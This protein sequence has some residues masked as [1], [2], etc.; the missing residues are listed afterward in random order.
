MT[1]N[2][3][4]QT[5]FVNEEIDLGELFKV[6]RSKWKLIVIALIL[7]S[8]AGYLISSLLPNQYATK[9][10]ILI[11]EDQQSDPLGQLQG[12]E[13][14]D[15]FGGLT[16]D[17]L[18]NEIE[19]LKSRTIIGNV[20][21]SLNLNVSYLNND[22]LVKAPIYR[23][24]MPFFV[25]ATQVKPLASGDDP[26]INIQLNVDGTTF[27]LNSE[28]GEKVYDLNT[29]IPLSF[30]NITVVPN[31]FYIEN[32]AG[33]HDNY[34]VTITDRESVIDYHI[35]NIRASIIEN[36][37]VINIAMESTSPK[38]SE[39]ILNSMVTFYNKNAIKNKNAISLNTSKFIER[40]LQI[41]SEELDSVETNKVDF[42]S[43]N[44]L[45]DIAFQAEKFV[46]NISE[47]K[48]KE[49][50]TLTKI[51]LV[52]SIVLDL[53]T[54][55]N[56]LIPTNIGVDNEEINVIINQYNTL[57][58]EK[59]RLL[60]SSTEKNPVVV[61]LNSKINKIK[62]NIIQS[63]K[64]YTSSLNILLQDIRGQ[65]SV[66]NNR[67]TEIPQQE[68]DYRFI[69][70]QQNIK[71]ALYLYLLRKRE[72]VS[73]VMSSQ[74]SMAR[75]LDVAYTPRKPIFPN[76]MLFTAGAGFVGMFL[77]FAYYF[78]LLFLK[79]KIETKDDLENIVGDIPIL[80]ELPNLKN[81]EQKVIGN[82]DRSIMAEALR[83]VR[84]NL[85]FLYIK[86][87]NTNAATKI[88]VTSSVKGEGKTLTAINLATILSNAS[89]KTLLL[90]ID[91]RN[92]QVSNYLQDVP[93]V[94][95]KH[96]G[97]VEY[98]KVNGEKDIS[99][100]TAYKCKNEYLDIILSGQ[101]P[102]NPAELLMDKA[103]LNSFFS[104]IE[105][106]Y[107]YI[108]L[109]SAPLMLVADSLEL[110]PHVDMTICMVRSNHTKIHDLKSVLNLCREGKIKNPSFLLNNV[111]MKYIKYGYEYAQ[112]S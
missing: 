13:S 84:S 36:S 40:R 38:L 30:C 110:S 80:G 34:E 87:E 96:Q 106:N 63:L 26:T 85:S 74:A 89:K 35:K 28:E 10:T 37:S 103:A 75:T 66:L 53:Q 69:E 61:D 52:K 108:I 50:E 82:D 59:E 64:M 43:I 72:E 77:V 33:K 100:I 57:V 65:E 44:K 17:F 16:S 76:K 5:S 88:L 32:E 25:V 49:L 94:H 18:Q 71:E 11:E 81:G 21:D 58:L 4:T 12:I 79:N 47:T 102:P 42:K 112:P 99:K 56:S 90:G 31:P 23:T 78:L 104:Q 1:R 3:N 8:I 48:K 98:L 45:T 41:I 24:N 6:L 67:V 14:L 83:V 105:N 62:F 70:R 101:I 39:D 22:A 109:D 27:M 2:P 86:K 111:D 95:L 54:N 15:L 68:K 60:E 55:N 107:D 91:L 9:T 51:E 97:L 20:V 92:P 29:R 7:F 19:I 46:E 93:G 73:V